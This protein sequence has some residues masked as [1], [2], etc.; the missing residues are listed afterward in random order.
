MTAP[1][2]SVGWLAEH[3]GDDLLLVDAT[4][5]LAGGDPE[6]TGAAS[7]ARHLE[8]HLP[9]AIFVDVTNEANDSSDLLFTLRPSAEFRRIIGGLGI[10]PAKHVVVYDQAE[11][12]A[13]GPG[14]SKWAARLRWQLRAEGFPRVSVLEGG[15]PAWRAAGH[16][17]ESGGTARPAI[18]IETAPGHGWFV[19]AAEVERVVADNDAVLLD[20]RAWKRYTGDPGL[21]AYRQGH[22]P[23]AIHFDQA[24]TLR[25]EDVLLRP[26][27]E[28]RTEFAARLPDADAR[29]V[30]YCG[31]G[32]SSAW[33]ALVLEALGYSRVAVYDGSILEWSRLG[34]E[35][36]VGN[37][38]RPAVTR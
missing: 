12:D 21:G 34:N 5:V 1:L 3:L 29:V 14:T 18:E 35:L 33:N 6:A 30:S 36:V 31:G 8:E 7:R 19:D 28:L 25:S 37:E 38:P 11:G 17:V 15:L 20:S 9:G 22:I 32:V 13:G 4:T 16:P 10:D 23:G 2:V 26:L 24:T 27:E